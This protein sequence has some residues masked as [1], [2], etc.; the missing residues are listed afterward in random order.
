MRK[1]LCGWSLLALALA[2]GLTGCIPSNVVARDDRMV[3]ARVAEL[4]FEPAPGL[5]L[6]GLYESVA[7]TGDAASSLRKIYYLFAA[8]GS[9]TAAALA[10]TDGVAA[11]QTLSGTWTTTPAGLALD[12]A[13]PVRLEQAPDHVRITAPNGTLVLRKGELQ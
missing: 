3:V 5:Q 2:S 10:E 6:A 4:K 13:E 9:Y 1:C 8:D 12:G 11:F 7:I